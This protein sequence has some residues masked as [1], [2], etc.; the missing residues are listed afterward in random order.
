MCPIGVW[1]FGKKIKS[2]CM[3]HWMKYLAM[4]GMIVFE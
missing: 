4:H 1:S 2:E 3:V